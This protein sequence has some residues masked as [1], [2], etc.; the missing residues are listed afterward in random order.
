[1]T[2]SQHPG[3]QPV[4]V[5]GLGLVGSAL[6]ARL[7]GAGF[8][9]LGWDVVAAQ[10]EAFAQRGGQCADSAADLA[11]RC[12]RVVVAVFD[13]DDVTRFVQDAPGLSLVVNCTTADPERI[14]A[15]ATQLAAQGVAHVEAPLSGSSEA[16]REGSALAFIA[17]SDADCEAAS[18]ILA[19]IAPQRVRVGAAGMGARAK[20]ASNLV[21]GLNRA[22][23]AEGMAFAQALGIPRKV[24]LDIVRDSPAASSAAIAKGEKMVSGDFRPE[25]RIRQHRKDVALMQAFASRAQLALPLT[26][27]HARLLDEAIAD[28]DADLDNA[29]LIR[30]WM[31]K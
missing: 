15:L 13:A 16:I 27:A 5:A 1:M 11:R 25:S 22:A 14:E 20:L 24:F 21:L 19:A 4:G 2:S 26:E 17:G 8:A 28:G 9:V 12:P 30:R 3:E 29:A 6:A 18:D 23:L 10:R 31:K 7:A